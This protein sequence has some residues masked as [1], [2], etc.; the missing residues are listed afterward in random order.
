VKSSIAKLI[1]EPEV[2]ERP[3]AKPTVIEIKSKDGRQLAIAQITP[4]SVVVEPC[5]D[6]RADLTPF[7]NFSIPKVLIPIREKHGGAYR[8]DADNQ[9]ILTS[10]SLQGSKLDGSRI[11]EL[12]G[13][14]RW[15]LERAVEKTGGT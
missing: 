5:V 3:T 8:V 15:T 12:I 13:A 11:K 2:A 10:I 6:V 14:V 4:E 9:S 1:G 7:T